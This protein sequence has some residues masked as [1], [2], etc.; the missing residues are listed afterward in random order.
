M[1]AYA[2]LN[3]AYERDGERTRCHSE[4]EG[5]LR[6]LKALYPE[7]EGICHHVVVHPPSG[8][9]GG[10]QLHLN[11]QLGAGSHAVLSTPGACRC[12]R[13][14]GPQSAQRVLAQVGANARLEWLPQE[15]IIYTGA[16]MLNQQRF[17]LALG[18][19]MLGWDVLA[20]GLPTADAP[21]TTGKVAQHIELP[22]V[23][24]DKALVDASDHTLLEGPTGWAGRRTLATAWLA[25]GEPSGADDAPARQAQRA[26]ELAREAIQALGSGEASMRLVAGVSAVQS[27]VVVVRALAQR[28]EPLQQLLVAVRRAWRTGLWGLSGDDLR[29][30]RM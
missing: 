30:W 27:Q 6:V 9:V 22:G 2:R 23:W 19:S 16:N 24:L 11:L 1:S 4:H 28:V 8:L 17:E 13:S 25:W 21:F 10:D 26:V 29:L 3:L 5:P 15:N 14:T 12:Y 20:L 18:A 7:G